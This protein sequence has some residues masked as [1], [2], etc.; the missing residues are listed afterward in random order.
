MGKVSA[1]TQRRLRPCAVDFRPDILSDEHVGAL[2]DVAFR[3]W[4]ELWVLARQPSAN[5][6]AEL[7]H[8]G[9]AQV[10]DDG[11]IPLQPPSAAGLRHALTKRSFTR[12]SRRH[13]RAAR[14]RDLGLCRYCRAPG[15]TFDHVIPRSRGGS[16]DITNIVVCCAP[17]NSRK[18]A[19]TPEEAGMTLLSPPGVPHA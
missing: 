13:C 15:R 14:E 1:V 10:D 16:D 8:H 11:A 12:W 19:R 4:I 17:C 7:V 6:L 5:A 18:W 3:A 2:S 9:L